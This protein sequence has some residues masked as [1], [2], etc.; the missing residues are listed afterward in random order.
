MKA[1]LGLSGKLIGTSTLI[2][3]T[4]AVVLT[5]IAW[6]FLESN[7]V[8]A[9]ERRGE[10]IALSLASAAE[11]TV[12]GDPS[13]LQG[14]ID[15]NKVI[16]GV[17]YIFVEDADRSLLAH[18]F[19][20]T[21]PAGFEKE[22]PVATGELSEGHRVKVNREIDFSLDNN[23]RVQAIDVAAPIASGELGVVHVGMDRGA[24]RAR[25]RRLR[26]RMILSGVLV[27]LAGI[28]L[29]STIILRGMVRPLQDAVAMAHRLAR[30]DLS[31]RIEPSSDDEVGALQHA[32]RDVV[33]NLTKA[34]LGVR[35]AA[36]MVA[37]ASGQLAVAS[38]A[39]SQGT[40]EQATS[41]EETTTSLD[42]MTAS[43]TQNAESSGRTGEIALHSAE[44]A[45]RSAQAVRDTVSAMS[46]I[47]ERVSIVEDIAQRTN[48][49]SLNASIEAARAG[50]QG[51][52]FSV[53]AAEVRKLS[54]RS[55]GAAKEIGTLAAESLAVAER[56]GRLLGELVP[57]IRKTAEL[58]QMVAA[59]S[60]EQS[61][62][63]GH[64]N[65]AMTEVERV[66]QR[67][68]ASAEELSATAAALSAQ[69]EALQRQVAF[70]IVAASAEP[71][72]IE[73]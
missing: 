73:G 62:G 64:I 30:G 11:Q 7:L 41:V 36:R 39:L 35:A 9:F 31:V 69:A 34:I 28:A 47:A 60:H 19:S 58:V 26:Q 27:A 53:V 40:V 12:D 25:V 46:A 16:E 37:S 13:V 67:N 63:V 33:G 21:F 52:G 49:L 45:E 14:A 57:T 65:R 10:A 29:F 72:R 6:R 18:T 4:V 1:R 42:Q 48:L 66:T 17:R 3:L 2:T 59:A 20:P 44:D 55:Q 43:I 70:F 51:R 56:S 22:N 5:V 61:T 23:V 24:I 54:E 8:E 68:A 15:S 38:R 50:D 71:E 32:L